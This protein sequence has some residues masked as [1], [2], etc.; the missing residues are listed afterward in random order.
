MKNL[1]FLFLFFAAGIPAT[2][3]QKLYNTQICQPVAFDRLSGVNENPHFK[4]TA[5][6]GCFVIENQPEVIINGINSIVFLGKEKQNSS[7]IPSAVC[8]FNRSHF[9]WHTQTENGWLVDIPDEYAE[10][11]SEAFSERGELKIEIC[12]LMPVPVYRLKY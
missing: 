10:C 5:H 3:A 4:I 7:E 8:G 1:I 12:Y 11:F 6:K 2:V 9:K